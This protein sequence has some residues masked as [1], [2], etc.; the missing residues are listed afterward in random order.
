MSVALLLVALPPVV[1]AA[2]PCNMP[3][4]EKPVHS[5]AVIQKTYGVDEQA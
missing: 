5:K 4:A 2:S 3:L 1:L